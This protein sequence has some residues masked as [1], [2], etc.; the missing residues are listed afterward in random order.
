MPSW[1]DEIRKYGSIETFGRIAVLFL[2]GIVLEVAARVFVPR[3]TARV[4]QRAS[5]VV[6][7][8]R[9][10]RTATVVK[11]STSVVR[12]VL[13]AIIFVSLLSEIN[14]NIGPILAGAGVFGAA[15]AFGAQNII[16]DYLA[17]FFILLEN[18]YT[19]GDVIRIGAITGAVEEVTMRITVLRGQDGA[20][21]VIPNGT[22]QSVSNMTSGWARVITDVSVAYDAKLDAA[23]GVLARVGREFREDKDWGHYLLE[24]PEVLGLN[25]ITD[26]A[27]V[28]RLQ[29]KVIPEYQWR[30]Q[31]ELL[32]R[33]K[34]E[35]DA[36]GI[37][38]PFAPA[39]PLATDGTAKAPT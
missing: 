26:T 1:V 8:E 33:I 22:I 28:V 13:W 25:A 5:Q 24:K 35:L 37:H 12:L 6:D 17:G 36:N 30:V 21:H 7:L 2:L 29:V 11:F 10:Q 27:M 31:R 14:I 38:P 19:L 34:L 16:K 9:I 32:R 39:V 3:V 15:V 23:L 18:Q 4:A 20:M